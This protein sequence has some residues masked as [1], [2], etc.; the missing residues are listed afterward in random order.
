M[1]GGKGTLLS[2][3]LLGFLNSSHLMAETPFGLWKPDLGWALSKAARYYAASADVKSIW[4]L[5]DYPGF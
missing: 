3:L 1:N 2:S 5:G 4:E